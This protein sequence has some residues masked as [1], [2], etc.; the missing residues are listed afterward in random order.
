MRGR[1]FQGL[2]GAAESEHVETIEYG[3]EVGGARR[4]VA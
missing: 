1:A 4:R 3:S 2:G